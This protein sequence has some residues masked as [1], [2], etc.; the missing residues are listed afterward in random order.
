MPLLSFSGANQCIHWR[1]CGGTDNCLMRTNSAQGSDPLI[2]CTVGKHFTVEKLIGRGSMSAVYLGKDGLNGAP[3]AVKFLNR[4]LL[5]DFEAQRRFQREARFLSKLN[6]PGIVGVRAFGVHHNGRPFLIMDHA[7]GESLEHMVQSRGKL[8]VSESLPYFIQIAE[9]LNWAHEQGIVHRD[10]KPEN[11]I[12]GENGSAKLIDFGVAAAIDATGDSL[13]LTQ[14]GVVLGSMCY[15]SPERVQGKPA[16]VRSEIYAM[17]CLMFEAVTGE[18][19][20][21]GK[22]PREVARHHLSTMPKVVIPGATTA[23]S[24]MPTIIARCLLKDPDERYQSFA[25]LVS[26][27]RIDYSL[28]MGNSKGHAAIK[29][30]QKRTM[31]TVFGDLINQS[32]GLFKFPRR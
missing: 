3:V 24:R 18:P 31:L 8:T 6:H 27:L 17:G 7:D 19:P 26:D 11:V 2:G 22:D 14:R 21:K 1:K 12:V 10:I 20:F 28:V 25:P 13:D 29:L 23:G 16:D 30:P 15:L 9:A 4:D 32:F 5:D